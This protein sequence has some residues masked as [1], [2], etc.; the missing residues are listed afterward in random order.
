MFKTIAAGFVGA[1]LFFGVAF[2]QTCPAY[3]YTL[4]NGTTADANQVMANFNTVRTCVVSLGTPPLRGYIAGLTLSTAGSS[5]S[6][7]ISPGVATDSTAAYSMTLGSA[8]SKTTGTWVAGSGNGCL[9]MGTI[10]NNTWYSE[11]LIERTDTGGV[12]IL[13]SASATTP[14]LPMSYSI[15]RR[16]GSMKTNGS[17]QWIQFSQN[18]DEFLWASAPV[19]ISGTLGTSLSNIQ[20]SVPTGVKV[21]ALLNFMNWSGTSAGAAYGWIFSPDAP[22]AL[23]AGIAQVSWVVGQTIG[24]AAINVRTNTNAQVQG[25]VSQS[26]VAVTLFTLGWIDARGRNN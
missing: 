26:S 16:I 19:D 7:A 22:Q 14:T 15:F 13:C 3:T 20:I 9:D 6:F 17:A 2:A 24:N 12:D 11:F 25:A 18:G 21:N 10:A 5:S 23:N 4:T 8:F 1:F